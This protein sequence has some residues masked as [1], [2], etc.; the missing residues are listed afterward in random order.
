MILIVTIGSAVMMVWSTVYSYPQIT[1]VTVLVT[2]Q[3][4]LFI[5]SALA[6]VSL[7]KCAR[8]HHHS[9]SRRL[10]SISRVDEILY[11][12][13]TSVEKHGNSPSESVYLFLD[14]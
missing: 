12:L 5:A 2:D 9:L 1:K 6:V 10:T 14:L 3:I 11:P 13:R 8:E 7:I 4:V